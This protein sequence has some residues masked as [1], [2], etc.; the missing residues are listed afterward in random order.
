MKLFDDALRVKKVSNH[1]LIE[2]NM[3][4]PM[5]HWWLNTKQWYLQCI[6]NEYIAVL[7]WDSL[8]PTPLQHSS[9]IDSPCGSEQPVRFPQISHSVAEWR[10]SQ[11]HLC[12]VCRQTHLTAIAQWPD[13]TGVTDKLLNTSAGYRVQAARKHINCMILT[14]ICIILALT[15]WGLD[16]WLLFSWM[17]MYEFRLKFHWSLF[18]RVQLT[19]TQHWFW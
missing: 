1:S 15:H 18:L 16:K 3:F 7:Y 10:H 17:K 4:I 2:I 11:F 6:C 5:T 13:Q 12:K 14:Y 8:N 9:Q 19:I